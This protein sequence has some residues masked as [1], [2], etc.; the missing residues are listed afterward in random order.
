M[1]YW[2]PLYAKRR[3]GYQHVHLLGLKTIRLVSR[4]ISPV[5]SPRPSAV[6][7]HMPT[8]LPSQVPFSWNRWKFGPSS[9]YLSLPYPLSPRFGT[10]IT[11]FLSSRADVNISETR[12][13]LQETKVC[14]D[15][16]ACNYLAGDL[17]DV[18]IGSCGYVYMYKD[19]WFKEKKLR[20]V[21]T[22]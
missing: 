5:P 3:K 1:A 18:R 8:L 6:L 16:V 2:A 4:A 13:W 15:F 10:R 19:G 9:P 12:I 14:S 17:T 22:R 21:F 20:F 11:P 7:L